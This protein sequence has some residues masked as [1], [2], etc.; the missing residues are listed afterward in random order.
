MID[1]NFQ[2]VDFIGE[3]AEKFPGKKFIYENGKAITFENLKET[4][5]KKARLYNEIFA[6]ENIV[7]I[8][9]ENSADFVSTV[10]ALWK[11]GKTPAPL[12]TMFSEVRLREALEIIGGDKAIVSSGFRN[13]PDNLAKIDISETGENPFSE[14][15]GLEKSRTALILFTSGTTGAS[16]AV[17]LTF[18]NLFANASSVARYFNYNE[19]NSWLASLPF[20]HIG[21]FSIITRAIFKCA[22]V[23]IPRSLSFRALA[24]EIERSKPS[25]FSVVQTTLKRIV[26]TDLKTYPELIAVFAGGGPIDAGTMRSAIAKGFPV[27]KVYGSTETASMITILSPDEFSN[28]PEAAGKAFDGI[29]IMTDKKNEIVVSGKQI[30]K[31]YY[32]NNQATEERFRNGKFFTGDIGK[33]DNEGFLF[34]TGRKEDFI[35]T[36]GENVNLQK[37]KKALLS[38]GNIEDAEAFALP[39]TEWGEK[40]CAVVVPKNKIT[41]AQIKSELA[42]TLAKYE[43]PK[44]I[45]CVKEIPRTDVGKAKT[46]EI[47]KMITES[48]SEKS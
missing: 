36:G 6:D 27:F 19:K 4:V 2:T 29:K 42:Q 25:F 48:S 12:N 30:A 41:A 13:L 21:G 11:T 3:C 47:I 9:S 5:D 37:V 35:I 16:K 32:N 43:I 8:I 31:S 1:V 24:E 23:I 17:P 28:K 18:E 20:Y 33:L 46:E 15:A 34:I 10:F 40:L 38:N 7:P 39:D 14:T 22:P 26:E 45:F 44:E